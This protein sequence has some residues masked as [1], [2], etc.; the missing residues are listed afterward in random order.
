MAIYTLKF[1]GDG[2]GSAKDIKFKAE[3]ASGA[4]IAAH[5]QAPHRDAELWRGAAKLCTIRRTAT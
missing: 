5:L 4:L 2:R 3:D 1:T